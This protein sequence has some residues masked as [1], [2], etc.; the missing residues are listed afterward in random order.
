MVCPNFAEPRNPASGHVV[1]QKRRSSGTVPRVNSRA[2]SP[3]SATRLRCPKGR[4]FFAIPFHTKVTLTLSHT[5]PI[6]IELC[7]HSLA[8]YR[9]PPLFQQSIRGARNA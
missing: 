1:L 9:L 8:G 6:L 5:V 7:N 4:I 3:A 2:G